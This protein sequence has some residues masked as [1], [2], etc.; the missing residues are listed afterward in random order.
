[1]RNY[2][3]NGLE[4]EI[5]MTYRIASYSRCSNDQINNRRLTIV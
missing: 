3:E 5:D 2:N 1:M 4:C